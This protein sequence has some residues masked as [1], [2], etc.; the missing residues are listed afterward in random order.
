MKRWKWGKGKNMLKYYCLMRKKC[1]LSL[2]KV[3]LFVTSVN[4]MMQ[5]NAP[6]PR[7]SG[8]LRQCTSQPKM[9]VQTLGLFTSIKRHV[10]QINV[11]TKSRKISH[12]IRS[13]IWTKYALILMRLLCSDCVFYSGVSHSSFCWS[14]FHWSSSANCQLIFSFCQIF[15]WAL[16]SSGLH[17][18]LHLG[19]VVCWIS[20]L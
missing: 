4:K 10:C 17:H 18:A 6:N 12:Q 11:N 20:G 2:N 5:R 13:Q 15:P 16:N 9:A 14:T 19:P 7:T 1:L 3:F 8:L